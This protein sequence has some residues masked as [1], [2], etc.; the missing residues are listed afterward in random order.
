MRR[1]FNFIFGAIIG[2]FVGAAAAI[3]LAPSSGDDLQL[4]IRDRFKGL[5]DELQAAAQDRKAEMEGQLQEMR[6]PQ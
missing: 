2:G 6:K 5:W 4:E 1:L 3:L